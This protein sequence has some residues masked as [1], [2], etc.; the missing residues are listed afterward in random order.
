MVRVSCSPPRRDG[1]LIG[2]R[3]VSAR[4]GGS[5]SRIHRGHRLP[6]LWIRRSMTLK[7]GFVEA[8]RA[9]VGPRGWSE[10]GQFWLAKI[11]PVLFT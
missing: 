8:A 4:W 6:N 11:D 9:M 3:A 7:A 1:R 10:R 5:S 2:G